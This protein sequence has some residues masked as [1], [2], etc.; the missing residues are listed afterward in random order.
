[1]KLR[2]AVALFQSIK[3]F[4]EY[5]SFYFAAETKLSLQASISSELLGRKLPH[6]AL[7]IPWS[8]MLAVA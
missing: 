7:L 6:Y 5:N 3:Y 8:T 1:L 4:I 2:L